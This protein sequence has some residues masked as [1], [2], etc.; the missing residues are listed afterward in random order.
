MK[1]P[2]I[3]FHMVSSINGKILTENWR[4]TNAW[5]S[6]APC[7]EGIYESFGADGWICGRVT[8]EKDFSNESPELTEPDTAINRETF[9]G[10]EKATSLAI[11]I[12]TKG[13]LGWKDNEIQGDHIIE[14]LSENVSDAYLYY[15][16]KKNI[17]YLF[18]GK[19]NIDFEYALEVLANSFQIKTLLLEG[20][21]YLNGSMLNTGLIDEFSLLLAP[22]ADALPGPTTFELGNYPKANSVWD[23]KLTSTQTLEGGTLWLRYKRN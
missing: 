12:D 5:K 9:I 14:V 10:N 8:L 23:L 4:H 18:A 2:Y 21:G 3:M 22:I 6:L 13:K 1:R 19:E 20:G 16:Q 15:L 17:S 7:F 11:A